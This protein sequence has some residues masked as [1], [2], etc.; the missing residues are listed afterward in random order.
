MVTAKVGDHFLK[1]DRDLKGDGYWRSASFALEKAIWLEDKMPWVA[2]DKS[3]P[4]FP[5]GRRM[6]CKVPC[7]TRFPAPT[8]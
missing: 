6:N 5:K 8:P 1:G 4:S 7:R 3:L 2:I